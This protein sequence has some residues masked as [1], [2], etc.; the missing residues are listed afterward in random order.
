[1]K[2][3]QPLLEA[4]PLIRT[5]NI[6]ELEFSLGRVIAKPKLELVNPDSEL[7]AF[8]NFIQL[9]RIGI[10]YGSYGTDIRFRFPEPNLFAQIFPLGGKAEVRVAGQSVI[11]DVDH[12]VVLSADADFTM[13]SSADY[14]RLNLN[15]RPTALIDVLSAVTG[16]PVA[17]PL[18]ID[19]APQLTI[20]MRSLQD[21]VIFL[22]QQ[23]SIAPRPP[24][25][26]LSEFEQAILVM[27]LHANKHN[28]SHLLEREPADVASRHVR[29]A[30]E[31]IEAH[32][33][34]P[35]RVEVLAAAIGVSTRSLFSTYR[36]CRGYSLAEFLRQTRLR[37]ARQMLQHPES[38]TTVENVAAACGF[39]HPSRFESDYLR[40]FREHP[41]QTLARS[42]GGIIT[43][44]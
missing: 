3:T 22:A 32:W 31:F 8:Q 27:F 39:G 21:H 25:L 41:S 15:I 24:D 9:R 19:P 28:Y 44:H 36:Q 29:S 14:E 34:K 16:E 10:L 5:S 30:E 17:A 11:T 40:A 18:K 43:W 38:S 20:S 7:E 37:H 26:L 12:S 1:M 6:D 33:D 23:L 2:P 13:A 42:R 4:F 35:M